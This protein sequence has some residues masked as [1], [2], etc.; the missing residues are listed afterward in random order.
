[1]WNVYFV[2]KSR[3]RYAR[4]S[5]SCFGYHLGCIMYLATL[6]ILPVNTLATF[7]WHP[8]ATCRW[9]RGGHVR[10]AA[11]QR[12]GHD[13][14]PAKHA[15]ASCSPAPQRQICTQ[16]QGVGGTETNP[17][18]LRSPRTQLLEKVIYS[19]NPVEAHHTNTAHMKWALPGQETLHQ[20]APPETP[21]TTAGAPTARPTASNKQ[22]AERRD[23][24]APD[25]STATSCERSVG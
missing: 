11:V 22:A 8:P 3:A 17:H 20:Q 13:H 18:V 23:Q 21:F 24:E 2:V 1:M 5:L 19:P 6:V 16:H 10:E 15:R 12:R 9:G 4:S 7:L 14:V 25:M